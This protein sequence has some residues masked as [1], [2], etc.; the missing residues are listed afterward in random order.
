VEGVLYTVSSND[1]SESEIL[2]HLKKEEDS[3]KIKSLEAG[4]SGRHYALVPEGVWLR[5]LK[6]LVTI[7]FCTIVL[8]WNI[9]WVCV[10]VCVCV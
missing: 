2:L 6:R 8:K 5:A 7:C 9:F 10:C 3:E 4:F 1:D